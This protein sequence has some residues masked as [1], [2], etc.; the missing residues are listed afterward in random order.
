MEIKNVELG[1]VLEISVKIIWL[2]EPKDVFNKGFDIQP[3]IVKD[4]ESE[5]KT[6]PTAYLDIKQP[7]INQF[8]VG[9]KIKLL[10]SFVKERRVGNQKWFTN[11]NK[12]E[13]L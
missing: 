5:D 12:I 3:A 9:D 7:Y 10:N 8:E 4:V 6:D 11:V 1:K 2:G 13:K